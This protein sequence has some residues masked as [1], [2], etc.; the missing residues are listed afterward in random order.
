MLTNKIKVDVL[1]KKPAYYG[2]ELEFFEEETYGEEVCVDSTNENSHSH[3]Q[4]I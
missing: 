2:I 3:V 1:P 4:S